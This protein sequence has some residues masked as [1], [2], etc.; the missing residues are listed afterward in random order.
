MNKLVSSLHVLS[1]HGVIYCIGILTKFSFY[2]CSALVTCIPTCT[3]QLISFCLIRL[4]R[5]FKYDWHCVTLSHVLV[6]YFWLTC[7][8]SLNLE[9]CFIFTSAEKIL[10]TPSRS[11]T[12][13]PLVLLLPKVRIIFYIH[14]TGLWPLFFFSPL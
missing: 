14:I 10:L 3:R 13:S 1:T 4:L 6:I 5:N 7:V 12:N 9:F 2:S 8:N 11:A